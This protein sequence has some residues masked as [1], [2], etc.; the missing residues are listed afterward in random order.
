MFLGTL[1]MNIFRQLRK[2]RKFTSTRFGGNFLAVSWQ[3][4]RKSSSVASLPAHGSQAAVF[5]YAMSDSDRSDSEDDDAPRR[6]P[7][8]YVHITDSR[9]IEVGPHFTYDGPVTLSEPPLLPTPRVQVSGCSEVHYGPALTYNGPVTVNQVF[10]VERLAIQQQDE[11]EDQVKAVVGSATWLR[12][13]PYVGLVVCLGT[14]SIIGIYLLVRNATSSGAKLDKMRLIRRWD[15]SAQN[16]SGVMIPL[17]HPVRYVVILHSADGEQC[18]TT[19]ECSE[20]V[21]G[22]QKFH[23]KTRGWSDIAYSFLVGGDGNVYEGRGWDARGAFAHK[24]N[25]VAIGI[26]YIGNFV[27]VLPPPVQMEAGHWIISQ[28]VQ[29]GKIADDYK[30]LAH[31]QVSKTESPGQAFFEVIKTWQHWAEFP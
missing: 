22:I 3:A 9:C 11:Q 30:L 13:L 24:Y 26:A 27:T 17:K 14:L 25:G 31:L 5:R 23:M 8:M 6:D 15:W 4:E 28:G 7:A 19:E 10:A 18:S 29:L 1:C 20:R 12:R 16:Q 2:E 21:R